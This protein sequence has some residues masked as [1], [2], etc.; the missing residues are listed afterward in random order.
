MKPLLLLAVLGS[1]CTRLCFAEMTP[2]DVASLPYDQV[3][4]QLPDADPEA[5]FIYATRL[6]NSGKKDSAIVWLYIGEL[7]A[8]FLANTRPDDT[9]GLLG[10]LSALDHRHG[11]PIFKWVA[12]DFEKWGRSIDEALDW[13]ASNRNG[14]TSKEKFK[15]QWAAARDSL[16]KTKKR[17]LEHQEEIRKELQEDEMKTEANQALQHNDR[18]RHGLCGRTLRASHDRG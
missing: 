14:V 5:Y 15:S 4:R 11:R 16:K 12:T 2:T 9:I 18:V 8:E 6:F 13:D 7:R 10:L 17:I 1:L 3:E